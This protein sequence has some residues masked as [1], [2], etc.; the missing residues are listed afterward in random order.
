MRAEGSEPGDLRR[1][2][3]VEGDVRLRDLLGT[4][5][6]PAGWRP[7]LVGSG[8]EAIAEL[9]R[10]PPVAVAFVALALA[11]GDGVTLIRRLTTEH[12]DLPVVVLS[13]CTEER[14]IVDAF[15]AGARGYLFKED[16][17]EGV[18][19]ALACVLA[20]GAPMSHAV[21]RLVLAQLRAESPMPRAGASPATTLTD[22]E[23]QVVAHFA[24]GFS[25][26]QVAAV[27]GISANTVRS[28]VRAIYEKLRVCSKTEA[29]LA[30]LRLGLLTA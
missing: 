28:Y 24:R 18:A 23:C 6:S 5:L 12:P 2:L 13:A 25:Y 20:G 15:R 16:L 14:R 17:G 26:G 11:D 3:V 9:R 19:A 27:L 10:P 29:V 4:L 1:F 22:R 30:A 8:A 21:A 7:V